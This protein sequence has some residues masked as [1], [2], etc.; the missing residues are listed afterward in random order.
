MTTLQVPVV[1]EFAEKF[2]GDWRLHWLGPVA[3]PTYPKIEVRFQKLV[4][5]NKPH[6]ATG[7][8]RS[9][10]VSV[11]QMPALL[12]GSI[13]RD[14]QLIATAARGEQ[15]STIEFDASQARRVRFKDIGL[16]GD[17][18]P[19]I[20]A[21]RDNG[22]FLAIPA[23]GD[24]LA[25]IVPAAEVVRFYY[26]P[27]TMLALATFLGHFLGDIERSPVINAERSFVADQGRHVGICLRPTFF[28]AEAPHIARIL[29]S[30]PAR[31]G[32][33]AIFQ[34]LQQGRLQG[35]GSSHLQAELPF[36][37]A[38]TWTCSSI[39][40]GAGSVLR[41][42]ILSITTCTA[43]FPFDR[44]TVGRDNSGKSTEPDPALGNQGRRPA[45][46]M[47]LQKGGSIDKQLQSQEKARS[48]M[49]SYRIPVGNEQFPGIAKIAVAMSY[50]EFNRYRAGLRD[51]KPLD[52]ALLGQLATTHGDFSKFSVPP[53]RATLEPPKAKREALGPSH[54]LIL[55]IVEA[56]SAT[57][58]FSANVRDLGAYSQ[59]PLDPRLSSRQWAY[60]DRKQGLPRNVMA[61]DIRHR[62]A[63]YLALDVDARPDEG[64]CLL[65]VFSA[66]ANW[67]AAGRVARIIVELRERRWIARAK[68][69]AEGARV[70]RFP[71]QSSNPQRFAQRIVDYILQS[72]QPPPPAA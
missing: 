24:P 49:R 50:P 66:D 54:E 34:S 32:A 70:Q 18:Y 19:M 31:R 8:I 23:G 37:G 42:L 55:G 48:E 17:V 41:H 35:S 10:S 1:R 11:G 14:G 53:A 38:T 28:N 59:I 71:H 13:W 36:T 46:V 39:P 15:T 61:A 56:L 44:L 4:P 7:S 16:R 22:A 52:A 60:L 9:C 57:E 45:W 27:S 2:P 29:F 33:G 72:G 30:A 6:K 69:L 12:I 64:K 62:D 21:D 3:G 43:R 47:P 58:G 68:A 63:W 26:A 65:L 25:Y 40:F 51:A 5:G 67:L 20:V